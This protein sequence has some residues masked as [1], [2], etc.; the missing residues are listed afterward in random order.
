MSAR[1]EQPCITLETEWGKNDNE[2]EVI[3]QKFEETIETITTPDLKKPEVVVKTFTKHNAMV[4][5]FHGNNVERLINTTW[6]DFANARKEFSHWTGPQ[7]FTQFQKC[8]RAEAQV[9]YYDLVQ[10]K[11]SDV[12]SQTES[13]FERM[14]PKYLTVIACAENQRDTCMYYLERVK[15]PLELSPADWL[16]R[17]NEMFH[18]IKMLEGKGTIPNEHTQKEM[19]FHSFPSKYQ[20]NFRDAG[21]IL[22]D[23]KKVQVVTFFNTLYV[24]DKK[25]GTYA[26]LSNK[27][28]NKNRHTSDDEDDD[29]ENDYKKKRRPNHRGNRN[30]G[31]RGGRGGY[32]NRNNNRNN[33]DRNG[34]GNGGNTPC[35]MHNGQHLW[36]DCYNN[37]HGRNFRA[38]NANG[39]GRGNGKNNSNDAHHNDDA[40]GKKS[41]A[42]NK[43]AEVNF[44]ES[45]SNGLFESD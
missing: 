11:Y 36:R 22:A 18:A 40:G 44:V 38:P 31:G 12:N 32:N 28:T 19:F 15:K 29:K 39:G 25:S 30:G 14:F 9:Q 2:K 10:D 6:L 20:K 7:L 13:A 21:K 17:W 37:R 33:G 4:R 24:E 16:T 5:T 8:L 3:K 1:Q 42:K 41:K 27:R 34:G 35:Q 23:M 45:A 43:N 26:Q